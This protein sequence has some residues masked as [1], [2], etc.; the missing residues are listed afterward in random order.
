MASDRTLM[1]VVRT[2][3]ALIGFGFTIFEFFRKLGEGVL[4]KGGLPSEAP[5][6]FGFAL[7]TLGI[8]LL[9]FGILNHYHDTKGRRRRRQALFDQELIGHAE[10]T[11][12]NSATIVA[13]LLLLVGLF[14]M[15]RV[16]L[17]LGPF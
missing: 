1:A 8:V 13:I 4:P 14:A 15:L 7:I 2:S 16:G 5:R 10:S 12:P 3:L 6:R 17:S 9:V 11:T